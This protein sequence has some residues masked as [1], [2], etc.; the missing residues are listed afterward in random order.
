MNRLEIKNKINEIENKYPYYHVDLH[1]DKFSKEDMTK[2]LKLYKQLN[3][4]REHD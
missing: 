3:K 2:L 1:R 4:K